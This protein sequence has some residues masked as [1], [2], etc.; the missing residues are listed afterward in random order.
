MCFS[1]AGAATRCCRGQPYSPTHH[2][3]FVSMYCVHASRSPVGGVVAVVHAPSVRYV[4]CWE[5][6]MVQQAD[7]CAA[8]VMG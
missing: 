3:D 1:L 5:G 6:S 2:K 8:G 7:E 4:V